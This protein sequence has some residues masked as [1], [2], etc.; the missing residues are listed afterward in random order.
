MDNEHKGVSIAFALVLVFTSFAVLSGHIGGSSNDGGLNSATPDSS[1]SQTSYSYIT[2]HSVGTNPNAIVSYGP[3][4]YVASLG[5]KSIAVFERAT[6]EGSFGIPG[7]ANGLAVAPYGSGELLL[8]SDYS[9][10]LVLVYD[11]SS[12]SSPSFQ[13]EVQTGSGPA[14]IT[15]DSSNGYVYVSDS[16]GSQI[17]YFPL[18]TIYPYPITPS[19]FNTGTNPE[20]IQYDPADGYVYALNE[21]STSSVISVL[22][23]GSSGVPAIYKTI[24]IGSSLATAYDSY[25][26]S[27]VAV[28]STEVYMMSQGSITNQYSASFGG[29]VSAVAEGPEGNILVSNLADSNLEI[30]DPGTGLS[31][32][33]VPGSNYHGVGY[34]SSTQYVYLSD[35]GNNAVDVIGVSFTYQVV[36]TETGLPTGTPWSVTMGGNTQSSTGSSITFSKNTGTYSYSVNTPSGFSASPSSSQIPIPGVSSVQITFSALTAAVSFSTIGTSSSAT[37]TVL[38]VDGTAYSLSSLPLTFVWAVG[39][40]HSFSWTTTLS[41]GA[42]EEYEFKTGTGLSTLSSGTITVPSG[43]GSITASYSPLYLVSFSVTPADDGTLSW[44]VGGNP[45]GSTQTSYS[46]VYYPSGQQISVTALP[47]SNF[48]FAGWT[49][50]NSG[51]AF[52]DPSSTP[53]TVSVNGPGTITANFLPASTFTVTFTESSLP[54][55]ATWSV[56]LGGQTESSTGTSIEFAEP[57]GTY[58]YSISTPT[59][60]T[61]SPSNGEV[62]VSGSQTVEVSIFPATDYY[63]VT[64]NES[65]LPS[66]SQWSATLGPNTL[67]SGGQDINF[68]VAPGSYNYILNDS[69]GYMIGKIT[70]SIDVQGALTVNVA[71]Y[72]PTFSIQVH[73]GSQNVEVL[74]NG[75][76]NSYNSLK[77]SQSNSVAAYFNSNLADPSNFPL[78]AVEFIQGAKYYQMGPQ[79]KEL[80]FNLY[81]WS[82]AVENNE[83]NLLTSTLNSYL[84]QD[85]SSIGN[86]WKQEAGIVLA[87]SLNIATV[88]GPIMQ[89]LEQLLGGQDAAEVATF[90]SLL[91]HIIDG[92]NALVNDYGSAN[93]NSLVSVLEQNHL[94][95]G[96]DYTAAELLYKMSTMSQSGIGTLADSLYGQVSS[97]PM[98]S[99]A[100]STA[101]KILGSIASAAFSSA[102][103]G[104]IAGAQ[105]FYEAYFG[106][107]LTLTT[108]LQAATSEAVSALSSDFLEAALPLAIASVIIQSYLLPMANLLQTEIDVQN[109]L[110]NVI[111]TDISSFGSLFSGSTANVGQGSTAIFGLGLMDALYASWFNADEQMTSQEYLY[112]L[113]NYNS[114]NAQMQKDKTLLSQFHRDASNLFSLSSSV[115][116]SVSATSVYKPLGPR[117]LS[118]STSAPSS[119]NL[120]GSILPK[121]AYVN[122]SLDLFPSGKVMVLQSNNS[123]PFNVTFGAFTLEPSGNFTNITG[124]YPFAIVT[125]WENT[126]IL[127]IYGAPSGSYVVSG[128]HFEKIEFQSVGQSG[129]AGYMNET[130]SSNSAVAA[131]FS[132]FSQS[133]S[134]KTAYYVYITESGLPSGADWFIN[135]TGIQNYSLKGNET[136]ILVLPNSTYLYIAYGPANYTLASP[137]GS[138]KVN[139]SSRNLVLN[140][141]HASPRINYPKYEQLFLKLSTLVMF[142]ALLVGAVYTAK[143]RKR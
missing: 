20:W 61:A 49:A 131:Y 83:G 84:S 72:D 6:F 134:L 58:S 122:S 46:G 41:Q 112:K 52:A 54:S 25:Y 47:N 126:S 82:S 116:K 44:M 11:L 114:W 22:S 51:L 103:G 43:G 107:E 7:E 142:L 60:Y 88:V 39:S 68:N 18:E 89:N 55:G 91:G 50:S 106:Y 120:S 13:T 37:G 81:I 97:S 92:Y 118:Y 111:S 66:G 59:G 95:S 76:Q 48:N 35:Y 108:S 128:S 109:Q 9:G 141:T 4:T 57:T 137:H 71:F 56:D 133:S 63:Q 16:S 105:I 73:N 104:A 45:A 98:S 36:F 129:A 125:N 115:G 80:L 40:S 86:E 8:I 10:N 132:N 85:K 31:T 143:K 3:Y 30:Y 38:T 79:W 69:S 14:G 93:A 17:T 100:S 33:P 110:A 1:S 34:D 87:N 27:I 70:G 26:S 32:A 139:G 102:T 140:F 65:G 29:T 42:P 23:V 124:N 15:F 5:G 12:P 113:T 64:F 24:D 19:S 127:S 2:S 121:D 21:P 119:G 99:T 94:V 78:N 28:S 96:S 62:S 90:V 136:T 123:L 101:T 77:N 67:S 53:T 135:V 138:F 75:S 74:V 117:A 130:L